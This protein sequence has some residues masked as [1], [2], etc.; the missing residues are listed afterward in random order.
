MNISSKNNLQEYIQKNKLNFPVYETFQ[1][2]KLWIC[3]LHINSK[4]YISDPYQNK[5]SAEKHSAEIALNDLKNNR[6]YDEIYL[7]SEN[8]TVIF[9][10]IENRQNDIIEFVNDVK[11]ENILILGFISNIHPL[12]DKITVQQEYRDPR[13]KIFFVPSS[14][15]DASDIGLSFLLGFFMSNFKDSY[16]NYIIIS[17][18]HF[19]K[20]L[21]E[22]INGDILNLQKN[23]KSA[24]FLS[25]KKSIP[26]LKNL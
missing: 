5:I 26:F 16:K 3:K 19:A 9:V 7:S 15:K 24:S 22:C 23:Y 25:I 17:G 11:S 13:V 8:K 4:T 1:I 12:V 10:D 18:D 20:V 2:N 6:S 14:R 21:E